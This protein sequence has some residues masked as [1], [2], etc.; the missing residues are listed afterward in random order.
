MQYHQQQRQRWP[1]VAVSVCFFALS[2]QSTLGFLSVPA[3]PKVSTEL[4]VSSKPPKYKN[5]SK[6]RTSSSKRSKPNA[7]KLQNTNRP[8]RPSGPRPILLDYEANRNRFVNR[9]RLQDSIGCPH[10]GECPG[11]VVDNQVGSVDII[12]SAKLYF[13]STSVRK[14]RADVIEQGLEWS[15]EE[16]D[17]GFYKVVVPSDITGWRTQAK[18]AVAP[19]S[20]SWANDGCQFGLFQRGTHNVLSIPDC[21]VHHPS[22][23]K[24]VHALVAATEAVGTPGFQES[25]REGGLRYV[26]FQ[27]ERLTGKVCLT[28]VWNAET[29]KQTQPN[30]SRLV[31]ELNKREP[32]LWHSVWCH[33][34]DGMGNN[35]FARSLRRWHR[36]SGPEFMR[37]PLPAGEHGWLYFSPLAFRQGNLDGFD[38]LAADVARAVPGGSK[39]CELYAGVGMLGLT[40]LAYHAEEGNP[41]EWIRCSDE[42]PANPKCFQRAVESLPAEVT[43]RVLGG[44]R[45]K[46]T[47]QG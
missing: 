10:F 29:L 45:K 17:D 11:C 28:L 12:E 40:A 21:A 20:S 14:D 8:T 33:C 24:A 19:K 26:Q 30:L 6:K 5:A 4:Y 36:M 34:N 41:L 47:Q 9:Q 16:H 35:I 15:T 2:F 27:V 38:V 13:S 23:N 22:I 32:E 31:K 44:Q 43:G 39:V 25:S 7:R 3:T 46:K 18:L 42:N 37:E 1:K